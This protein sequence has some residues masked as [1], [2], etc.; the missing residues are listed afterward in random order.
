MLPLLRQVAEGDQPVQSAIRAL[1]DQFHL[2]PEDRQA[3]LPSG[4]PVFS[5]RVQWAATYLVQAGLL[6]RPRRGVLQITERGRA[7]LAENLNKIDNQFLSQFEGFNDFR[8]RSRS[9]RGNKVESFSPASQIS[10][11]I[12][13]QPPL[14]RIDA[15]LEDLNAALRTDLLN[16]IRAAPATFFEQLVV[17]LMR[18][19]GYGAGGGGKRLGRPNDEGIDGVIT[20][21]AL[22]LDTVYLQAKRYGADLV[23]GIKDIQAF[24]GALVGHGAT[25]GVFVTTSHFSNQARQFA[26]RASQQR[27]ILI[28]GEELMIRLVR[29]GVGV[30]TTRSIDLRQIDEDYFERSLLVLN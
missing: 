21:D 24:I 8:Q 28:D 3:V 9:A 20:Q 14:E 27:I 18:A 1:A 6:T 5:S 7:A 17:D 25:K 26:G 2:A 15:A 13:D 16:R 19:M 11:I 12:P 23:V 4:T 22:G 29:Y 10:E 30:R